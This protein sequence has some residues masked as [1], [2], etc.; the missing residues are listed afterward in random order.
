MN[1]TAS[2]IIRI[3]ILLWLSGCENFSGPSRSGPKETSKYLSQNDKHIDLKPSVIRESVSPKFIEL[4]MET[5]CWY[6]SEGHQHCGRKV[7]EIFVIEFCHW[8]IESNYSY[9]AKTVQ[10]AKTCAIAPLLTY[11]KALSGRH[12]N[13]EATEKLGNSN[14]SSITKWGALS[15]L[16]NDNN[17]NN[18]N[19]FI[20]L[21][22][23][24]RDK[25]RDKYSC[26]CSLV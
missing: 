25:K 22:F 2:Q 5:P 20:Y 8:S 11:A 4:C 19:S 14:A 26:C 9:I 13:V 6:P 1:K 10:L 7:T 12:F 23:W 17:N 15:N 24:I 21:F 16:H 18:N 3:G